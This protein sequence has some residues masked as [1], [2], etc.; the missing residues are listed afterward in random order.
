LAKYKPQQ[1]EELLRLLQNFE[2]GV[3]CV[4]EIKTE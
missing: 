3:A 1:E 4:E 2:N